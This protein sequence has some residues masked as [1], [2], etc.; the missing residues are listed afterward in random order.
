M[1]Y[2]YIFFFFFF[3]FF[4]FF[5]EKR[6]EPRGMRE[7]GHSKTGVPTTKFFI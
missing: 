6:Y 4:V 7:G 2:L 3:F 5:F 1:I